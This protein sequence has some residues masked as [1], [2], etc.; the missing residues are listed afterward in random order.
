MYRPPKLVNRFLEWYCNPKVLEDLQGDL[1]EL[2]E[3]KYERQ[4]HFKANITFIWLVIRSFRWSNFKPSESYQINTLGMYKNYFKIAL[5]SLTRSKLY[6]GIN[7]SGLAVGMA[8][9]MLIFLYVKDELSYDDYHKKGDNIYRVVSDLTVPDNFFQF[10]LTPPH[11]GARLKED[12]PEVQE[13]VRFSSLRGLIKF[14]E[15]SFKDEVGL[16]TEPSFFNFFDIPLIAGDKQKAL[17][18]P[19]TV[20]LSESTAKKYFGDED[21]IGKFLKLDGVEQ[22]F[23]ITGIIQDVPHNTHFQFDYLV[24]FS[25]REALGIIQEGQWFY[26][27]YYTYIMLP[28]SFDTSELQAKLP[29]FIEKH[30]GDD[31]RQAG[32]TFQFQFQPLKD[33]YLKSHRDVEMGAN[34]SLQYIYIFSL[35]AIFIVV[36]ACVNFMN[37]STARSSKRAKE[38]GL[39]KVVG[40]VKRQL[41]TQFLLESIIIAVFAFVFAL[42]LTIMVLPSFNSIISKELLANDLFTNEMLLFW[43]MLICTTGFLAGIYP[44]LVL[45]GFKPISAL[46]ASAVTGRENTL[47]RKGLVVFQLIISTI[48]IMGTI[49][50]SQQLNSMQNRNLGFDKDQMLMVYYASDQEV[51]NKMEELRVELKKNPEV[52]E[53]SFSRFTPSTGVSNWYT[54]YEVSPGEIQNASMYG[55]LV[56]FDFIDT[57]GLEMVAGRAFDP[58]MGTDADE[59]FIVNETAALKMGSESLEDVIGKEISQFG[60]Q[61]K[62]IGIVKDFNFKTLHSEI[63]PLVIQL[64]SPGNF[65]M[66]SIKLNAGTQLH[67]LESLENSWNNVISTIPFDAYFLDQELNDRYETEIR[68]G[69]VFGIFSGLAIFIAALGLFALSTL[70]AEQQKKDISVRKVLGATEGGIVYGFANQFLRLALIAFLISVPATF[71]LAESWLENFTYRI[72]VNVSTF[73]LGGGVILLITLLTISFQSFRLTRL[74]PAQNLRSE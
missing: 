66:A 41:V 5:R 43:T 26:L 8:V 32:Q 18:D 49:V 42:G 3:R 53:V 46:R 37:L 28:E 30:I 36:I 19:Y 27:D 1:L 38:I 21:P 68:T 15:N 24:S 65:A 51:Q 67:T 62:V 2:C 39:R 55:Y 56:D 60:K 35:V 70:S 22:R 74:N 71:L 31:Q 50:I 57:Y 29:N 52:S 33:I 72:N 69:K 48:L 25:T 4:G 63:E 61:G 17:S 45:S 14:D 16:F 59:A 6:S 13:Y 54:T 34:G 11:L 20:V 12:F 44:A 9:F 47:L 73:L 40:A 64:G 7:I 23:S 10:A 58:S